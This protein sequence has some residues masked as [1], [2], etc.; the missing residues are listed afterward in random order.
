MRYRHEITLPVHDDRRSR[1]RGQ[2]RAHVD[3]QQRV[4]ETTSH[5]R[6]YCGALHRRERATHERARDAR[7]DPVSGP[8]LSPVIEAVLKTLDELRG[9]AR[10]AAV[11]GELVVVGLSGGQ[12]PEDDQR[13][14]APRIGC[15]KHRRDRPCLRLAQDRG[16]LDPRS[17]HH[18][19][20]IL[21][22]LLE[23]RDVRDR[24]RN[25]GARLVVEHQPAE[26]RH[27][28]EHASHPASAHCRSR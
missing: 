20:H 9:L 15:R 1:D 14:G 4:D 3:P 2:S 16:V 17:F 12:R 8:A 10:T 25:A 19:A 18:D 24:I 27:P 5:P 7:H 13:V 11:G 28:L 21:D 22:A 6:R 23:R 26:P